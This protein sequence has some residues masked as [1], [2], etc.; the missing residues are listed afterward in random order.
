MPA[1]QLREKGIEAGDDFFLEIYDD[2]SGVVVP[3]VVYGPHQ[4]VE[5]LTPE[6]LDVL[7]DAW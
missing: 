1:N 4:E 3:K 2:G 5:F 6:E 7:G